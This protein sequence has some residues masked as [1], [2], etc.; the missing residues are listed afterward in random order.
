MTD[1]VVIDSSVALAWVLSD[2]DGRRLE[3]VLDVPD[4]PVLLAPAV[5]R[6]E[7]ANGLLQALRRRRITESESA[8]AID[9]VRSLD[10]EIDMGRGQRSFEEAFH[11]ARDCGLTS[12]DAAYLDLAMVEGA[13]LCT[14][15]SALS[16]VARDVGVA[17]V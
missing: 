14:L 6:L 1:R 9:L 15:D 5:W 8:H 7:V 3:K 16:K 11:L 4:P 13:P 10:A 2:E 12:Y 17:L